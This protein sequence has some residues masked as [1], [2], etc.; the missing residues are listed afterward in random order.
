MATL[1][2]AGILARLAKEVAPFHW[3]DLTS[4]ANNKPFLG[5]QKPSANG[6]AG[7]EVRPAKENGEQGRAGE[8]LLLA[9]EIKGTRG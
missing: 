7:A 4:Q 8:S 1:E 2:R 9:I 6:Y 5:A 3:R